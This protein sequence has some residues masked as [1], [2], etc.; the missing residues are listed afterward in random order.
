MPTGSASRPSTRRSSCARPASAGRSS[1]STRS[2]RRG[3][4]TRPARHRG[5][6]RR[7]RRCSPRR[8]RG[9]AAAV[10][11]A[12]R[13]EVELEVE[14]G[15]GR[16]GFAAARRSRPPP[17]WSRPPGARA[18]RLWTHLQ[19]PEDP[20]RS[21]V[22]PGRPGFR[23]R[24]APRRSSRGR[25]RPAAP[26]TSSASAALLHRASACPALS[27]ASGPA[28]SIYGLV[29]DELV[30]R[31]PR[32]GRAA[33]L[34]PVMSLH[35]RPVRVVDLPA[36][37][38]DQLRADLPDGPPEPDRDPAARLRRRLVPGAVEPG[39]ARSSAAGGCRSS[40]TWRWTRVMVDVTDVPGAPVDV[41]DEFVLIGAQGAETDHGRRAG[42]ASAPR[43]RGRSSRRCP[44]RLPRV[45]H[46]AAGP[47]GL[48][49]LTERR[50][51]GWRASSSGTATSATSRSTRS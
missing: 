24:A 44:A 3:S 10:A 11:G 35:A 39:R 21:R 12:G 27:T 18:R 38:G 30:R 8:L 49:T 9:T 23:G 16:G 47:V 25:D 50:A 29:P 14:T 36:G 42:A 20:R 13:C 46:A 33:R 40:G 22:A 32:A 5:R 2:R 37:H 17:G 43:T 51:I 1:S 26:A 28:C 15:L 45:Y 6:G 41:D 4:A 19:A 7:P 31:P 48:R 34:R